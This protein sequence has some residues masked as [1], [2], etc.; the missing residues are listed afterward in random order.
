M[1]E[2]KDLEGNTQRCTLW[3]DYAVQFN[4]YVEKNK[5]GEHVITIMQHVILNEFRENVTVQSNKFGTR[6]F[7][8]EDIQQAHDFR[9]RLI[10]QEGA[11]QTSNASLS[12][13]TLYPNR[14]EFLLNSE[15]KHLDEVRE[16]EQVGECGVVA[17]IAMLEK[18]FGWFFIGCQKCLKKVVSK[19]EYLQVAPEEDVTEELM[20]SPADS[21]WC[22]KEKKMATQVGPRFRVTMRVQDNTG[23]ASFVMWD[24]DVQKLL[25][26]NAADIRQR[27]VNN[28]EEDNYPHELDGLLNQKVAFKIKIDDYNVKHKDGAYTINKICDDPDII[29]EL[30]SQDANNE[31]IQD[32]TMQA[33]IQEAIQEGTIPEVS[34]VKLGDES[35]SGL[36]SKLGCGV[37]AGCI[38]GYRRF[39]SCRD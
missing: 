1:L 29:A 22:R 17:T 28:N 25:G 8:N 11:T 32:T 33:V 10:V 35:L 39:F 27:Q 12:T 14:L 38:L 21:I 7:I 19:S 4:D 16:A 37:F 9:K 5:S 24:R 30:I 23:S 13:Q 31:V 2:L 6:I 36:D 18:E 20:N 34:T 3:N 15:K 26:L